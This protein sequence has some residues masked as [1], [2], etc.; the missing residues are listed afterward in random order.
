MSEYGYIKYRT[1]DIAKEVLAIGE[2]CFTVKDEH[3]EGILNVFNM[4]V[5]NN[6]NVKETL[7]GYREELIQ[8]RDK[9]GIDLAS[10]LRVNACRAVLNE[11]YNYII[12]GWYAYNATRDFLTR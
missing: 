1:A 4:G 8:L 3:E 2:R 7:D 11:V 6:E 9:A 5:Y 10:N 12:D